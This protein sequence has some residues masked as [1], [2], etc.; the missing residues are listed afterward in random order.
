MTRMNQTLLIKL[1]NSPSP[2]PK[3]KEVLTY[4]KRLHSRMFPD[5]KMFIE[6]LTAQNIDRQYESAEHI[7]QRLCYFSNFPPSYYAIMDVVCVEHFQKN[8]ISD[9]ANHIPRDHFLH[10]VYLYLLGIYVFFYDTEF[11]SMIVDGNRFERA[12]TVL[13][14]LEF[15][16]IK[17]FISEWKYFCLFH[18]VGY[19]PEILGNKDLY[20]TQEKKAQIQEQLFN[21]SGGYK[22]SFKRKETLKQIT[23]YGT[24]EIISKMVFSWIVVQNSEKTVSS[25]HKIFKQFKE[26]TLL[27]RCEDNS[28]ITPV[29]FDEMPSCCVTGRVLD[30][31]VCSNQCLK[32][33]L[34]I[35]DIGKITVF[36]YNKESGQLDFVFFTGK[37]GRR[38][39]IFT[40][41]SKTDAELNTFFTSPELVL[42]DD[43]SPCGYDFEYVLT[44][45][46]SL[47]G[48][49]LKLLG[50]TKCF[51]SVCKQL[52]EEYEDSYKRIRQEEQFLDFSFII[53]SWLC[54]TIEPS[55][56]GTPLERYLDGLKFSF[57]GRQQESI[58]NEMSNRH[59]ILLEHILKSISKYQNEV[60]QA[61]NDLL[62]QEIEKHLPNVSKFDS[63]EDMIEEHTREYFRCV[64]TITGAKRRGV[65][66]DK[67]EQIVL[68]KLQD[69]I[70]LMELF[71]HIY[72]QVKNTLN[73]SDSWF[74]YDYIRSK[75]V[76]PNFLST[77]ISDK[78][79]TQMKMSIDDV[80]KEYELRHGITVDH[81]IASACYAASVF[82][83]YRRAIEEATSPQERL[84]LSILLDIPGRIENSKI[85]YISNYDHV[86][87]SVLFAIFTHNLYP[88]HFLKASKGRQYKTKMTDPFS[89]LALLCDSLQEWNR[90]K[91]MHPARLH[92][93]AIRK[94]SEEFNIEVS[95][96][97]IVISDIATK[98]PEW[99]SQ[100]I[101]GL[102]EFL[103]S[104]GAYV[105]KD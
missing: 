23:Y 98:S 61:S 37:E 30:K 39:F 68:K 25:S 26:Q 81:G 10:L 6:F 4:F 35:L 67:L 84:L 86:F 9:A 48:D 13:G 19:T 73:K 91:N 64:K 36:A 7:I 41:Q 24:I 75:V 8:E 55:Y 65:F 78:L 45:N 99:P 80:E 104:I 94:A 97:G 17:D 29:N 53:F 5:S 62:A 43:Y 47:L 22:A 58:I 21:S 34:P 89:Y 92:R 87:S 76:K 1:F 100:F 66:K 93:E 54:K 31:R 95:E 85:G 2:Q 83:C 56:Y 33:L 90:P 96:G 63:V 60:R 74:E 101:S 16:C 38:E 82:S 59:K 102:S 69:E 18:D 27:H 50:I 11:Y 72:V 20:K 14:N 28:Q 70:E 44:G 79:R 105:R 46:E 77:C 103:D 3:R 52:Y 57:G 42:F 49:Q 88:D 51:S 40:E 15:C 71:S 32:Q 12:G